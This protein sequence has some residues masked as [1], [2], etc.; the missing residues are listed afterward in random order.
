MHA[1]GEFPNILYRSFET[2]EYAQNFCS[3]Q[4]RFGSVIGYQKIEDEKR[5]DETEG[6]GHFV[7]AGVDS[8]VKFA[9]NQPYALCCHLSLASALET[10]H[11]K[12]IVEINNSIWLAE[13]LTRVIGLSSSKY[14]GGIEG[15]IISYTKGQIFEEKPGSYEI[16]QLA[17]SQKPEKFKHENEFRFVFI[18]KEFGGNNITIQLP[19]SIPG[20]IIHEYT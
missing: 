2:L 15:V 6:V 7:V 3:G 5:K 16:S 12:F 14:F 18:R 11:G 9:S 10:K 20:S 1:H 13:E 8:K 4:I 17:Y 19:S